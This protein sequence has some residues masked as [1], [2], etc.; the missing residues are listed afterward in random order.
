MTALNHAAAII[1]PA[2]HFT[3]ELSLKAIIKEKCNVIYG[4]PTSKLI[5]IRKLKLPISL[6]DLFSVC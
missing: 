5:I 3:P 4:T 2:P 1:L 6:I